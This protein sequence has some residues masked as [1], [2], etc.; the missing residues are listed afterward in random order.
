M[1]LPAIF[2]TVLSGYLGTALFG[3]WMNWPQG[4][5]VCA[6]AVMGA[7]LLYAIENKKK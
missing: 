1:I 4:G 7:F 5:P 2:A 3:E 6:V